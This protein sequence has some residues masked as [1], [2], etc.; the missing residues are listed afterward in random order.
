M[1]RAW[2]YDR[3]GQPDFAAR[4]RKAKSAGRKPPARWMVM[5]YDRANKLRSEVAPNKTAAEDRRDKIAESLAGGTYVDPNLSKVAVGEMAEKWL[6]S[7]H[8]LKP[9]TWWKYRGLLD[10][11]VIPRWGETPLNA[12]LGEDIAVWVAE[13]VK[14]TK[15]KGSGL[16]PSQAR[17]AYRV[18]AMVLEWCVPTRIPRN[19]ARGVKPPIPLEAEHVYLSYDQVEKLAAAAGELRT[20]Y[21]KPTACAAVN[22]AFILLLAYTGMRWGEAA[23]LRVG[24]VDLDKRRI[25]IAVTFTEVGG[26]QHE[27]LPKT[28][29]KRTVSIPASLVP[30]LKP[31]K[32]DRADTELLFTTKRGD[33]L[34]SHNW[35]T[36]EFNAAVHAAGLE[37]DG[38]TPHKLRHTAASLAIAAGADVK[39]VQQMLGHADASMTLNIY[40]HLWPDRLDE[41]A[42][43][44]DFRRGQALERM[45]A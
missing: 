31:L 42:D 13:L 33:S 6:A 28:G 36:R 39:V 25:R 24:R 30:L 41:V 14:S 32:E 37:V 21:D 45:A 43:A 17:H 23:A 12:V 34:R 8:D 11:H 27:V 7:R 29:K 9:S 22:R 19:P 18:L 4:V 1:A 16:G 10:N 35:R 40:G 15:D 3:S 26:V 38:L 5:Y 20:K 2:I 44:L